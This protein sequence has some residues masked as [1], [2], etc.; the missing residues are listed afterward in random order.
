[1]EHRGNSEG[2]EPAIGHVSQVLKHVARGKTAYAEAQYVIGKRHLAI[3]S[4][5]QH[6]RDSS[7][8]VLIKDCGLLQSNRPNHLESELNVSAFITEHPVGAGGEPLK[9][10]AARP[11][12]NLYLS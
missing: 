5:F 11:Q 7:F 10:A 3:D 4:F 8:H 6:F 2:F 12:K 1:M 9:Q